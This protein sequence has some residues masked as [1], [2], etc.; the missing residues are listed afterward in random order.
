MIRTRMTIASRINEF[1]GRI[2]MTM[3]KCYIKKKKWDEMNASE[4]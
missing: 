2:F 1:A 4:Y 3:G